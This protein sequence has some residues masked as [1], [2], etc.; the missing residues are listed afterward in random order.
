M[1]AIDYL[2]IN[3][4][5]WDARTAI[6]A[7]SKFYD[8][9]SFIAGATSLQ[10]IELK[11]IGDVTDKTL[12][13]LQ[14][15]FG[16]DTLSWAR[17]GAVVTGVD[18]S[19]KAIEKAKEL[20]ETIGLAERSHFIA[21]D[22]YSFGEINEKQYDIVFVSYGAINWLPDLNRWAN[23][24]ARA[25]KKGGEFHLVEF[26]PVYDLVSGYSYFNQGDPD[27]DDEGTY[28]ENDDEKE[29]HT[30][31]TWGHSMSE[32][33]TALISSGLIITRLDEFDYSPYDCFEGMKKRKEKEFVI[34]KYG[35]SIPLTYAITA[36]KQ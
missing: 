28:T 15:H 7:K 4:K 26:H 32:I 23:V 1:N 34:E 11:Q 9:P 3:Q 27:I 8:I 13:H 19:P 21:Q 29:T 2:A 33:I 12:L 18:L 25:L 5:A 17:M 31:A 20:A 30:M 35:H 22:V 10:S 6:H 24:I 14:C 16:M 36:V